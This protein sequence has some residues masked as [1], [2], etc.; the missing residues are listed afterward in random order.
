MWYWER[1]KKTYGWCEEQVLREP[2]PWREVRLHKVQGENE[3]FLK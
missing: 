3:L 1:A 2:E